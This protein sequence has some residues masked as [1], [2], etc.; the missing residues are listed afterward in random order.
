RPRRDG[1]AE[2]WARSI[3]AVPGERGPAAARNVIGLIGD[4][5]REAVIVHLTTGVDAAAE[6]NIPR[7]TSADAH[8][9]AIP[10]PLRALRVPVL[11]DKV[12]G[13]GHPQRALTEERRLD[14]VIAALLLTCGWESRIIRHSDAE[15]V[16]AG[17]IGER[18][19]GPREAAV[20]IV[21]VPDVH[22]QA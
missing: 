8:P 2:A 9:D 13:V 5:D 10:V 22:G 1:A 12:L 11:A 20:P 15:L 18:V 14:V 16:V 21:V 7:Q 6:R 3:E 17:W 4:V 19:L